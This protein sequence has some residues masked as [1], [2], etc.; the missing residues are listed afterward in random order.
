MTPAEKMAK[1]LDSISY[2]IVDV[3]DAAALIRRLA[4]ALVDAM[5]YVRGLESTKMP[6]ICVNDMRE[7]HAAALHDVTEMP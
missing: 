4:A 1:A 6:R 7:R 2:G 3:S 5:D